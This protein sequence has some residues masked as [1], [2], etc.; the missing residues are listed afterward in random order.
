MNSVETGSPLLSYVRGASI[1]DGLDSAEWHEQADVVVVGLGAAGASAAIALRDAGKSVAVVERFEGGGATA[2]SGGI[3]YAGATEHLANAG[4]TDT[5]EDMFAY[6][7]SEVGDAVDD[8]LLMDFCKNSS[9]LIGWLE[10]L[11]IQFGSHVDMEKRSYPRCNYDL[12]FSGNERAN[13]S[14]RFARPAPRGHRVK[15]KGF[16]GR[17]LAETL[18]DNATRKGVD[19]YR[20][21]R[22]ESLVVD[23]QGAV[24]GVEVRSIPRGSKGW[25][26]HTSLVRKINRYQRFIP[27]LTFNTLR[28]L[29]EIE[30]QFGVVHR[31]RARDGVILATGSFSFNREMIEEYAPVYR[32]ALPLGAAGCDGSGMQ[33]GRSV[34]GALTLMDRVSAWRSISPP[35][36]FVEGIVVNRSG[37]RFIAEDIYLG[38]LGRAIVED[39]EDSAWVVVDSQGYKNALW[40]ALPRPNQSWGTFGAPL[41][42][43][44]LLG[45]KRAST[46]VKLANVC[47]IDADCLVNTVEQYNQYSEQGEEPFGK[48]EKYLKP[49]SKGPFYA[50]DIS[51]KSRYFPCPSIPMGGLKVLPSTG[52]VMRDDGSCIDGLYAAGRCAA[53][54]PSG[55][56]VSGTSLADCI[57]S[58]RRAARSIVN[59]GVSQLS[60]DK[61]T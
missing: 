56:Y 7:K 8:S 52:S 35:V 18:I 58:G 21:T 57:Y 10:N 30:N 37:R 39:Q 4:Y 3:V 15:G 22:V 26:R 14:K 55:F 40:E 44:L 20:H 1:C 48:S 38:H 27:A 53:G 47:D 34:G 28:R 24:I 5:V 29:R 2:L 6:L 16:T 33:L 12:Y 41:L 25:R 36:S 42:V 51:T 31:I 19:I 11:G 17:V 23:E 61:C 50:L 46:L 32:D 43:N 60:V 54:I 59:R 49:L 13:S 45:A 9:D